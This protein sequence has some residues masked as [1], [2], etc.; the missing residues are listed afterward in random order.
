MHIRKAKV[1][2]LQTCVRYDLQTFPSPHSNILATIG[3]DGPIH[4]ADCQL[5]CSIKL[6]PMVMRGHNNLLVSRLCLPDPPSFSHRETKWLRVMF[7]VQAPRLGTRS[8][9]SHSQC[10]SRRSLTIP[11]CLPNRSR[12]HRSSSAP[13]QPLWITNRKLQMK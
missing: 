8:R 2:H 10:Y 6:V 13:P 4:K 9:L 3:D 11:R 5:C 1:L 7:Q 12:Q